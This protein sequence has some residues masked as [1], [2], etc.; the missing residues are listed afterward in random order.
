MRNST[1]VSLLACFLALALPRQTAAATEADLPKLVSAA[2]TY[3]SGQN[4]EPLWKLEQ[5]LRDSFGKP[6]LRAEL[7][8]GLVKL[9]APGATFEAR[10]FA[11]QWLAAIGSDA[12]LPAL[13]KLLANDETAGIACLALS[14]RRSPQVAATLRAALR[15]A[16][17]LARLQ[18][19][20]ALGNHQDPQSVTALAELARNADPAVAATAIVALGKIG[21]AAAQG[22]IA[23]L[24]AKAQPAQAAALT[25]AALRVAEQL[26][27]AGDRN[28]AA[29]MYAELLRPGSPANVRRSALA[30]LMQNDSDGGQQRILDVLGGSDALLVPVAIARVARL[31]SADASKTFADLLPRLSPPA[32]VW[33]IEALASRGDAAARRCIRA[34]A[35][36]ADPGVRR[37]AIAAVGQ[38]EDASAAALLVKLLADA[39]SPDEVQNLELALTS[40]RGGAAT[41]AA[42]V[43]ELKQAPA[44]AKA[45]LFSVLTSRGARAALPALLAEAGGADIATAQPALRALGRLAGAADLPALLDALVSL[46]AGDARADAES[47]AARTMARIPDVAQRSKT[48]R[49]TLAKSSGVD[50]RCSL[51]RL[52]PSAADASALAALETAAADQEPRIRDAAV[53]AL[54]AWPDATGWNVL[55]AVFRRPESNTHR[56]LALRA[57]VR[58]AGDLNA[59]PDA[60]LIERYRQ[61]FAGARNDGER[62]LILSA[63]AGAPHPD[64]L[65]LALPLLANAGVRAEAELAVKKIAAAVK[66]QHPKAAQAALA[67]LKR[68]KP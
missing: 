12:S 22:V 60:A 37:A 25:D 52:L 3:E 48:V 7:E 54:A 57:L 53:R 68:A 61:L 18:V 49:M 27:A 42:L 30:A 56:A 50:A 20:G 43:A 28:A 6:A 55:A 33:M 39:K 16:R 19:I 38:L 62:K 51:L 45:C 2:A 67:Q 66:A 36:A 8:A 31:K 58:L 23:A 26:A 64:A 14:S 24:R 59:K 1:L 15:S 41:D 32:Q 47:A 34:A 9:L 65:E 35:S 21:S 44:A 11:C 10:R 13:G 17:G 46:K 40:L 4:A 29:A 5:L 63:L